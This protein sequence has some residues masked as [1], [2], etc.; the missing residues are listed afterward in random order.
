MFLKFIRDTVSTSSVFLFCFFF[1]ELYLKFVDPRPSTGLLPWRFV[2][3]ILCV[4]DVLSLWWRPLV[5]RPHLSSAGPENAKPQLPVLT[6]PSTPYVPCSGACLTAFWMVFCLSRYFPLAEAQVNCHLC[7]AFPNP[8]AE[9][10]A[11]PLRCQA[12][13]QLCNRLSLAV[14]PETTRK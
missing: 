9:C 1:A 3:S 13:W 4:S 14:S 2:F 10:S 11:R 8:Q 12:S 6:H 5:H 7:M